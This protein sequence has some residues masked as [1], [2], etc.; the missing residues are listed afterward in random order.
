MRKKYRKYPW[1]MTR[2][3]A[4]GFSQ[5]DAAI[6]CGF[7]DNYFNKTIHGTREMSAPEALMIS[8]GLDMSLYEVITGEKEKSIA[9]DLMEMKGLVKRIHERQ[10]KDISYLSDEH[11]Q[12]NQPV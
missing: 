3:K 1:L 2:A 11:D 9:S 12:A 7:N 8:K 4:L 5:K 6:K 10:F